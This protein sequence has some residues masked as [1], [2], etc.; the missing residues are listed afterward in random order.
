VSLAPT[1]VLVAEAVANGGAVPAFN[2]LSL[3]HVEAVATGAAQ[4]G[5]PALLQLSENAIAFRG[6]PEP[7][8]AACREVAKASG[9]P[10][11]IHLDHIEDRALVDRVLARAQEFGVGS[12]MFDASRLDYADNVAETREVVRRAHDAGV[13]VEAEL[14]E[15]GGKDGAHAPGV[16]TDPAEAAAFVA[17]T[18]VDGL[19]VAVGSSHAMRDRSA[20]LDLDL[21]ARLAA[22]VPV[23]LVLHGSSGVADDVIAA[24][25]AAGIRKVNV[26]TALNIAFTGS[27]RAALADQ[28]DAVDPRRYTRD[29][30]AAMAE[31]VAR[32]CR[33]VDAR[34][35]TA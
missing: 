9:S 14:G 2:V 30:R 3:D 12:I 35:P 27:L 13:W 7:L 31:L 29:A 26:G 17:A 21:I 1:R 23:P 18:G 4:A 11:G 22:A 8:L 28:P 10:L 16:R 25:V 19:A 34:L 6:A 33:V 20:R 24:A 5:S 32:F 15:I